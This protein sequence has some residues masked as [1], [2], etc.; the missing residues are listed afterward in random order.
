MPT[1]FEPCAVIP[2]YNHSETIGAVVNGLQSC[3]LHC[4]LVDD[5]SGA[6]CALVLDHL[7]A[8][9]SKATL[10]RLPANRGKGAAVAAGLRAARAAGYSHALQIDADGQHTIEDVPAFLAAAQQQPDVVICGLP[11]F[12][13]TIPRS[14][15]YGRGF[16]LLWARINTLSTD[17]RDAMCGFRIYPVGLTDDLIAAESVGARMDFDT[18]ILV[19]LHWRGVP[20]RWLDTRVVYPVGG[21][22]HFRLW[23]DNILISC[24]HARLF[25]GMLF[26]LPLLLS[27]KWA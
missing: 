3:G 16:S 12:D 5:G 9:T 13:A 18:E 25:F 24:M 1:A 19:R 14:R 4:I 23:R 26:R 15:L 6:A 17:I 7:V 10:V 21:V 22:S 20:M 11:V 8:Q 27:R 2:V